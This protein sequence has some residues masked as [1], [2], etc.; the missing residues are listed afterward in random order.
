MHRADISLD[1]YAYDRTRP[2][3]AWHSFKAPDEIHAR[4]S[5]R[6]GYL[7]ARPLRQ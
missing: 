1:I 2:E 3:L 7:I 5:R 6:W 4:Y